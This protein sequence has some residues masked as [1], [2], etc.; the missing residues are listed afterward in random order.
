MQASSWRAG[1]AGDGA[2]L[3]SA[4]SVATGA[5]VA[6]LV[7]GAGLVIYLSVNAVTHPATLAIQATHFATWPTEGT[8]RVLALAATVLAAAWLRLVTVLHPGSW[9]GS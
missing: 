8:L 5:A 4:A 1:R 9:I 2:P 6:A 7:G 3:S